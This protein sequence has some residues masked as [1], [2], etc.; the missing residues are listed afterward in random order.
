MRSGTLG[1][2]FLASAL[3]WVACEQPI[4]PEDLQPSFEISDAVH[5]GGN[6]NF[7]WLP[8]VA[9][10]PQTAGTFQ[11]RLSP[12]V[13]ICAWASEC[14]GTVWTF[15]LATGVGSERVGIDVH[16][17]FYHLNWRT[18]EVVPQ[19]DVIYRV[20][21]LLG[22]PLVPIGWADF[23]FFDGGGGAKNPKSQEVIPLADGRTL[24]LKFRIEAEMFDFDIAYHSPR[25]GDYEIYLMDRGM[26]VHIPLTD[27]PA[28]DGG[29]EWSPDGRQIAFFSDREGV[30][31]LYV[32]DADGSNVRP[33]VAPEHRMPGVADWKPAWSPD[34]QWIAFQRGMDKDTDRSPDIYVL[35]VAGGAPIRLTFDGPPPG[36]RYEDIDPA[37]HPDGWLTYAK[38]HDEEEPC[39]FPPPPPSP[40][41][42]VFH[43]ACNFDLLTVGVPG[44]PTP[45][46]PRFT[47]EPEVD[48]SS[49]AWSHDGLQLVFAQSTGESTSDLWK[50]VLLPFPP[51]QAKVPVVLSPGTVNQDPDWS[52]A[53]DEILFTS[54]RDSETLDLWVVRPNGAN[55]ALLVPNAWWGRY[56]PLPPP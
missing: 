40:P 18:D 6:P 22:E 7:Y 45:L 14:V 24:P 35:P 25:D 54:D 29:P 10:Q 17:Q 13:Q 9:F 1:G 8:P 34:G 46:R 23:Q 36:T 26:G 12:V 50:V 47:A 32:M 33:L 16:G 56:R 52:P 21:V 37:W 38:S 27:D 44:G 4:P 15:T 19:P 3:L 30:F 20:S 39:V 11:P 41:P 2:L 43:V 5:S 28:M 48:Q 42:P 53:D 49:P 31:N 55:A 51:G